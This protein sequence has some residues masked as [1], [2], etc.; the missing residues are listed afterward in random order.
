MRTSVLKPC[1][2][3]AV[4]FLAGASC[5]GGDSPTDPTPVCSYTLSPGSRAFGSDGGT[6]SVTVAAAAGCDW[7]ATA[8]AGWISVSG[9]GSGPGTVTYSVAANSAAESRS[10]SIAIGGQNHAVTQEGRSPTACTYSLSPSNADFTKDAATGNIG[11]TAPAGCAWTAASNA[12]WVTISSGNQGSGDGTVSYAVAAN[13]EAAS[14]NATITV[15][16]RAFT[17]RQSGDLGVCQYSVTP[18]ELRPCHPAGTVTATITTGASCPWTATPNASW[19]GLPGG[20]SGSGSGVITIT[21]PD[22]YDAP[23]EGIVMVR[24][25]TPT[26]GQ[27]VRVAQAGC[28]YAVSQAQLSFAA[29]GGPGSFSVLQTSD[30]IT[31]GGATQNRCIWTAQ[32]DVPWITISGSMP[33]MGDDLLGFTV[34]A[35]DSTAARTGRITVKDKVVVVTQSGR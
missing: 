35:N 5:G 2:L 31:C 9:S 22:N 16:D 17:V 10:G 25:P 4:A 33:R 1:L 27:N 14:R 30:P 3:V 21:Y 12:P 24:W 15:A 19:L 34:A 13:R 18:V 23:R 6:G 11:V 32:S 29:A 20:T 7:T 8:S 26:A 28:H